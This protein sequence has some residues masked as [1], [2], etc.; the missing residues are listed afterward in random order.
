MNANT[1]SHRNGSRG[2]HLSDAELQ[3]LL[4]DEETGEQFRSATEHLDGC[5]ACQ[6]QLTSLAG[7]P[8]LWDE[9]HSFLSGEQNP[10][11]EPDMSQSLV[12]TADSAI[13][14]PPIEDHVL[15]LLGAPN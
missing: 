4:A 7:G 9:A 12:V 14:R 15:R 8:E 3:L 5:T 11:W 6:S 13:G 1:I 10:R 2:G